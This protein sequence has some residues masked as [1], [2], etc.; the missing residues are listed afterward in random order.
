MISYQKLCFNSKT[1]PATNKLNIRK[2]FTSSSHNLKKE[3]C[4]IASYYLN[5]KYMVPV[6]AFVLPLGK[7]RHDGCAGDA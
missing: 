1:I 4:H 7:G 6:G 2:L 5:N 3:S